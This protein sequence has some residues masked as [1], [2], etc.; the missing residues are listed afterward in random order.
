MLDCYIAR[1]QELVNYIC[2]NKNGM[3]LLLA[4]SDGTKYENFT[5]KFR[6]QAGSRISNAAKSTRAE[7]LEVDPI[8]LKYLMR[9]YFDILSRI[10]V[11][12]HDRQEMHDMLR[13]VALVYKNGMI[14][15]MRGKL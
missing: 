5:D 4:C 6:V 12:T 13:D 8:L 1:L 15:L 7:N 9:G 14:S 11:E 3:I 2:D 10:V